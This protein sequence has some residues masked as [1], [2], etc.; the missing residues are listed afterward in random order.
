[1][2]KHIAMWNDPTIKTEFNVLLTYK[3]N[4][5]IIQFTNLNRSNDFIIQNPAKT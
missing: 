4:I 3:S 1:M 5:A 2:M